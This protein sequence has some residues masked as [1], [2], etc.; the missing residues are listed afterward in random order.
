LKTVLLT[1]RPAASVM[2]RCS[3]ADHEIR[4]LI[5]GTQA[6]RCSYPSRYA[7]GQRLVLEPIGKLRA[8][9]STVKWYDPSAPVSAQFDNGKQT[10]TPA[11]GAFASDSE[12]TPAK[13]TSRGVTRLDVG[14]V[15]SEDW[16]QATTNAAKA[17]AR[18]RI[19]IQ[20]IG[21]SGTAATL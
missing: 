8:A 11:S 13:V 14:W 9:G 6:P 20:R 18:S 17:S 3:V 21:F 2:V 5:S 15:G 16:A 4:L 10:D 19:A 12:M 7:Y 1:R